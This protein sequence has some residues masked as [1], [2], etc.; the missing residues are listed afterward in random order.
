MIAANSCGLIERSNGVAQVFLGANNSSGK[1]YALTEGQFSDDGVAINSF[2]STAF[3]AATG[4]SGRNLFGYLTAYVQGAGSLSLTSFSPGD[5]SVLSLVDTRRTGFA[6]HGAVH[7]RAGRTG[8]VSGWHERG[9]VVVLDHQAGA[10]G[11]A[12]SLR[13]RT[14]DELNRHIQIA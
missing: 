4:L 3:L 8:V 11:E 14:R 6:R 13:H 9:G 10:V 12:G 1:I 5:V 7:K 2:Y